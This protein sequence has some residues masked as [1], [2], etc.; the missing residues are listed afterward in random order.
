M[1][2]N[3]EIRRKE[4]EIILRVPEGW[5]LVIKNQ[6]WNGMKRKQEGKGRYNY[7]GG[8]GGACAKGSNWLQKE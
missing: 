7:R 8:H 1:Q 4:K 3:E 6:P 5:V 2:L